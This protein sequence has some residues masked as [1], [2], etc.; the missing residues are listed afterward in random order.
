MWNST[1]PYIFNTITKSQPNFKDRKLTTKKEII[2]ETNQRNSEDFD[3]TLALFSL[4]L[5]S[6]VLL[7]LVTF[8]SHWIFLVTLF[9]FSSRSLPLISCLLE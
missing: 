6:S 4:N 8:S 9:A 1:T 5:P 2:R 3:V 7:P